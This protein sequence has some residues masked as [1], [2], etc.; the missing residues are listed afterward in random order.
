LRTAEDAGRKGGENGHGTARHRYRRSAS[1][2][3]S[4]A[5]RPRAPDI[6]FPR[7]DGPVA[8]KLAIFDLDGTLADSAGWLFGVLNQVADRYGFRR[9]RLDGTR[10]TPLQ[11]VCFL[12]EPRERRPA[13]IGHARRDAEVLEDEPGARRLGDPAVIQNGDRARA[14]YALPAD[15]GGPVAPLGQGRLRRSRQADRAGGVRPAK[16]ASDRASRTTMAPS[17][18]ASASG[19]ITGSPSSSG[20]LGL[21]VRLPASRRPAGHGGQAR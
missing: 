20:M 2:G 14:V 17:S 19:A 13:P 15:L 8:Y 11:G 1:D 3:R 16:A 5:R 18:A 6:P 9:D 7:L 4:I 12:Q 21:Q 10:R